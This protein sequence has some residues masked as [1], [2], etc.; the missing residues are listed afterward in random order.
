MTRK[1]IFIIIAMLLA[2]L[3]LGVAVAKKT[4]LSENIAAPAMSEDDHE[5]EGCEEEHDE[6]AGHE[7]DEDLDD[8]DA[9]DEQVH[10]E[11][12]G[13]DVHDEQD[14]GSILLDQEQARQF[15]IKVARAEPGKLEIWVNLPGEITFNA[16][17]LA[18]IVPSV[19][20]IV[21]EVV[22]DVGDQVVAGE[23]IAWLE[24]AELGQAKVEYLTKQAEVSCCSI[25]LVRAKDVHDNTLKLLETLKSS[26]TLETLR[27][28]NG[29]AMGMNRSLLISAYAEFIFAQEAYMREKYLFEKQISSKE[30]FLKAQSDFRKADAQYIATEDSV[31]FEVRRDFLEAKRTQYL[32]A[33]EL[34]AAERTLYILGLNAEDVKA[35]AALAKSQSLPEPEEQECNDPNC[36]ECLA[37]A[38]DQGMSV[39]DVGVTNEKLAWYPIRAPFNGT[40][41]NKHLTLGEFA[42]NDAEILV[43]A[44]LDNVWVDLNVYQKDLAAIKKGQKVMVSAGEALPDVEGVIGYVGPVVGQESRTAL[45]RVVLPNESGMLR[46][47]LFVTAKVAVD[48]I[49]AGV[50]VHKEA[51]QNLKGRKCVFIRDQHGYEP[52]YVVLGRY[53][54]DYVEVTSGLEPGQQ[55]VTEGAF[56]LK[57][58]IIT[59]TLDSHAGHGH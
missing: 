16:N 43:I 31:D 2:G 46:P 53:D 37:K 56:E 40:I 41:I 10:E 18:H 50:I 4:Y 48:D 25:E 17:R 51:V 45:A 59:S 26:P 5:C 29:S 44:D 27:K 39:T 19:P 55:Y 58:K 33:V 35:L 21:R 13:L 47:G 6:T 24:S 15:G 7:E 12:E 20:G 38:K 32:N 23:V 1:R 9:H 49:D 11:D 8:H 14:G 42:A 57:A 3:F 52:R 34:T 22:K 54:T 36:K 30:D 28:M